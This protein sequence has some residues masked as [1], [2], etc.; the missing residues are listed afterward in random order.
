MPRTQGLLVKALF[1]N[2]DGRL[3]NGQR[4]RTRVQVESKERLSV[5]FAAVTQSSGQSFVFRIGTLKSLR[6][7]PGKVD[8]E[9]IKQGHSVRGVIAL[10]H[11]LCPA[12]AG[13]GLGSLQ[14]NR[15]PVTQGWS[16]I[17]R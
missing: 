3:R 11:I 12:D 6:L 14:N 1:A 2:P 16:S 9:R 8:L 5:P 4:L 10:H 13:A 15:Y 17:K 7:K